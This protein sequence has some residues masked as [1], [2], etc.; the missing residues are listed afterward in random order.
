MHLLTPAICIDC[1]LIEES[2]ETEIYEALWQRGTVKKDTLNNFEERRVQI[3]SK[4]LSL[5]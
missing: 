2:W 3:I 5:I 1:R 4:K